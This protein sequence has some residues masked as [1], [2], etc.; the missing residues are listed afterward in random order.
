VGFGVVGY[1]LGEER[2]TRKGPMGSK[3]E[4]YDAEMAGLAWAASDAV[5]F[6]S[7]HS[8]VRHL[9][10]FA[11]NTA[12]LGA[13]FDPR[14]APGQGHARRFRM[15]IE[16]FLERNPENTVDIDWSPGHEDIKGNERADTLAKSAA[17]LPCTGESTSMTHAKRAAKENTLRKWTGTWDKTYPTGRFAAADRFPPSWKPKPHF[18]GTRRE[19]YG[20]IVQCR[21]GHAFMGEYYAKFVPTESVRCRCGER[22][23]TRAHI[24][25]E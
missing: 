19:V 11:D 16:K 7:T 12:A 5:N 2:M 23:Q 18:F 17:E 3:S 4:V 22:F 6:A 25:R 20:R 24:L 9:H 10:F 15:C 14:P 21:T 13:I 1:Y 8:E